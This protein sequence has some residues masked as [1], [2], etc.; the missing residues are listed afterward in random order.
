MPVYPGA[1]ATLQET[2]RQLA[3]WGDSEETFVRRVLEH[4]PPAPENHLK[5]LEYNLEGVLPE[6]DVTELEAGANRCAVS[7]G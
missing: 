2:A 5:I 4:L 6:G 3:D 1:L 7:K